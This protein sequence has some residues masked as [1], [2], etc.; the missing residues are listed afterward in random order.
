M[1]AASASAEPYLRSEPMGSAHLVTLARPVNRNALTD[2]FCTAI[3][4]EL[5]RIARAGEA[6]AILLTGDGGH[7]SVGGD[8]G[9]LVSLRG[10]ADAPRIAAGIAAFQTLIRTVVALPIPVIAL[11]QGS[12]A[13]FG[14]DLAL[15]CDYRIAGESLQATSAF[16]RMGLVPDGGSSY[17]LRTLMPA[18]AAFKFLTTGEVASAT[19]ALH[20]GL[21]DQVVP[22]AGLL[23]AGLAFVGAVAAQP[24]SSV[25]AIKA[26]VRRTDIAALEDALAAEAKAQVEAASGPDFGARA[27]AFLNRKK[28]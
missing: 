5:L 14:L 6:R 13:G 25:G 19:H 7:F 11:V 3:A 18:G 23:D 24:A 9:W 20:L 4:D 15:A 27:H 22:D 8:L 2:D 12:A 26:L 17:S 16:A 10:S 21:V 28:G 1:T